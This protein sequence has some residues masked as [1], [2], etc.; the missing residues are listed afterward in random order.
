MNVSCGVLKAVLNTRA[1]LVIVVESTLPTR[2]RC[3]FYGGYLSRSYFD[4]MMQYSPQEICVLPLRNRVDLLQMEAQLRHLF[5]TD[6]SAHCHALQIASYVTFRNEC[7]RLMDSNG[8][9]TASASLSDGYRLE[10]V[11]Q[12]V[13]ITRL[14]FQVKTMMESEEDPMD[15]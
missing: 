9:G 8:D 4:V 15:I 11:N 3:F 14:T 13:R 10:Y 2:I 6:P 5:K 7:L 12:C 1:Y